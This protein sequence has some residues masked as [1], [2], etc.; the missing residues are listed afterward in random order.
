MSDSR[1]RLLETPQKTFLLLGP[2]GTGK[3]TWLKQ[4][5]SP[6]VFINLLN[7]EVFFRYKANPELIRRDLEN[8]HAG[9]W[10]VIDEAQRVPE[11]LNEVHGL[12]ESKGIH[13]AITGSS[14][15]KLKR[16][17]ANL[18]AGRA[19]RCDFFPFVFPEISNFASISECIEYGT[20]PPVVVD[21]VHAAE[22]LS[23]YVE[24]YLK[25]EIA[26]E[27]LARQLEPFVR[28][29]RVAAQN[30][31]QHLNVESVA[32]DCAVKRRTVDNY[33]AI[34]EETLL[35]FRLPAL[36][37]R[38]RTK[39]T[40]HPKFYFFDAGVARAA[41]GWIRESLPDT[42]RGYS[43]ETLVLNE[44]RAFNSYKKKDRSI[45]HYD[46]AGS[47]DID[48]VVETRKKVLQV[49][50]SYIAIEV[51]FAKKWEREWSLP[52]IAVTADAKTR[53]AASYGVYLGE[54]IIEEGAL[55]IL[56]FAEFSRRLWDGKLF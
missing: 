5:L 43:F 52:L 21:G 22:T 14:A 23:A 8:L 44:I 38:W 19:I 2:R 56:P 40:T 18:L 10:V 54:K 13:F 12:Y 53:I 41:A 36:S 48:I 37:L 7:S 4:K 25:E 34:L 55:T 33:F 50:P 29:L 31:A 49:P 26:A 15:R 1:W 30:H 17:H 24:T 35:G 42:W 3:T 32:R 46:V 16:S 6:K 51:K 47:M 27:A 9:E 11:L 39:E 20:L 28:F 45:F